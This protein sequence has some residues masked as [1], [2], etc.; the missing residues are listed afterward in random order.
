MSEKAA[1]EQHRKKLKV[2][3]RTVFSFLKMQQYHPA[4]EGATCKYVKLSHT[5]CY[6]L[7]RSIIYNGC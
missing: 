2:N 3:L 7:Y 6:I 5:A 4:A 1:S